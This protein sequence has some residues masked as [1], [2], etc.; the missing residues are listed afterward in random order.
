MRG[1][2]QLI[3]LRRRGKKPAA[4]HVWCGKDGTGWSLDW[5]DCGS[6]VAWIEVNDDESL[7]GLDLRC[8]VGL[9]VVVQGDIERRVRGVCR[10]AL[11][12][13]ARSVI[14]DFTGPD[15]ASVRI[16]MVVEHEH[17]AA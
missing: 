2:E 15:G 16:E 5:F 14:G 4:A 3:A 8:L 6:V 17:A 9:A 10:M 12:A 11:E 7:A 1:H 13:G